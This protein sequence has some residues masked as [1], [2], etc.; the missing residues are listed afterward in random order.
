MNIR[1]WWDTLQDRERHVLSISGL[2][3]GI[4]FIY[5]V[6]WSPLS[7][8]VDDR[9]I[10][11]Q[12][13]QQLLQYI[14][15]ANA[16]IAQYK[17]MGITVENTSSNANGLLS[18]VEQTAAAAQLSAHLKQ[19]QQ[20]AKNQLSLTFENVPFDPLLQWLQTLSTTHGVRVSEISATRL[21]TL[22]VVNVKMVLR[23]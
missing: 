20:T 5:M 19:V 16:T 3:G 1:N 8:A 18:L 23:M 11:V 14:H 13:Q 17:A 6:M 21:P 9:K 7:N 12:S 22:G 15:H 4:L 2:I 10:Q